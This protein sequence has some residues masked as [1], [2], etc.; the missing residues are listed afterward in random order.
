MLAIVNSPRTEI[1]LS[2]VGAG[3]VLEVLKAH[4]PVKILEA[5]PAALVTQEEARLAADPGE[6]LVDLSETEWWKQNHFRVLTGCRLRRNMTQAKLAEL[7]GLKK[8]VISEYENGKRRIT[9]AAAEKLA[10][11]LDTY[12]EKF[13]PD[14]PGK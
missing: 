10:K 1:S 14:E 13:L 7:T 5:E 11:A 2:G 4:F 8:S 12:P 3:D 9:R 6:E